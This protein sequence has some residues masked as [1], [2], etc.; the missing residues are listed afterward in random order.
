MFRKRS[1]AFTLFL[2]A[3]APL[4]MARAGTPDHG[5]LVLL[6]TIPLPQ[7]APLAAW[8]IS[9][10]D[11]ESQLM[12]FT[13]RSNGTVDVIDT[14]HDTFVKGIAGGF[15]GF[16][17]NNGTSGPNGVTSSDHWLFVS[18]APSRV[19]TIDLR[20]DRVVSSVSTGGG[21]D[22]GTGLGLR[23]DE[24]AYDP[25]DG[26]LLVAN[27][28]DTPPFATL[29]TVEPGSGKL[30]VLKRITYTTA[31]N[32]AEASLWDPQTRLF[33]QS[34]P[35][36]NGNGGTSPHGAIARIAPDGTEEPSFGVDGCQPAGLALGG[37]QNLLLG[38]SVVFDTAGQPWDPTDTNS[39]AP[40]SLVIDARAGAIVRTIAGVSG[41]DE[42]W[43]NPGDS[44]YYLAAKADPIGPVIGVVG[45]DTHRP[46]QLVPTFGNAHSLAAN[47]HNNHVF[48]PLGADNVFPGCLNGCVAVFGRE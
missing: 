30:T 35:E 39:A 18:D 47:P 48:V 31:T 1:F 21:I 22:P 16:T 17:G 13:D 46:P 43:F 44:Q 10:V 23:A 6:T 27:N 19:V 20:T 15:A 5:A 38:C 33:Y 11:A 34:I 3:L 45:A 7:K 41:S 24:L 36:V 26:I 25:D 29:L 4:P 2:L 37:N 32:G 40:V 28:A 8:D 14:K 12:Y 42:V 9:W